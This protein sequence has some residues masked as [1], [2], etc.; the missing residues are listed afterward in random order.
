M[1]NLRSVNTEGGMGISTLP[2]IIRA[3]L[4]AFVVHTCKYTIKYNDVG[5]VSTLCGRLS[6]VGFL[7]GLLA[8]LGALSLA[9]RSITPH[10]YSTYR[11]S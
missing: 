1:D 11:V 9:W 6:A 2:V 5:I 8:P 7:V 4:F 3:I 10:N